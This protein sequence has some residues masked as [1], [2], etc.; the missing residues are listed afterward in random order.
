MSEILVPYI[1]SMCFVAALQTEFKVWVNV[2]TEYSVDIKN[3]VDGTIVHIR[4]I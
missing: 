3:S 2:C 4:Q 1:V